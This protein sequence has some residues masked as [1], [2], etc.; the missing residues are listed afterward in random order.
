MRLRLLLVLLVFALAPG[1]QAT[2]VVPPSFPELVGEADAIYRG[3]VTSVQARRVERTDGEGSVIKTFV[4]LAVE[5]VLK[6][7]ERT[8]VSRPR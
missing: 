4:T 5:R 6:G 1:V 3:R 2:T 7:P 8:E